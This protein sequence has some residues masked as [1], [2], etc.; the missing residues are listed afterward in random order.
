MRRPTCLL[1]LVIAAMGSLSVSAGGGSADSLAGTVAPV[2]DSTGNSSA[3]A[4]GSDCPDACIEIYDPVCGSDGQLYD[5]ECFFQIAQC[6]S[7]ESGLVIAPDAQCAG[8]DASVGGESS[9][10]SDKCADQV[11]TMDYSPVCGSDGNTYS[12]SCMLE[13]AQCKESTLHKVGDG[14]CERSGVTGSSSVEGDADPYVGDSSST[15]DSQAGEADPIVC[16]SSSIGSYNETE[17]SS[18]PE[19]CPMIYSPV[20]GSDGNTYSNACA[21]SVASCNNPEL[22]LTQAGDGECSGDSTTTQDA[23]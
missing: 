1:L 19:M 9:T 4:V 12:N 14:E 6:Q 20:C 11:C 21:L 16:D 7:P 8:S 18:C 23:V 17:K 5:N 13:L 3:S 15:F 2:Q 10:S 22:N